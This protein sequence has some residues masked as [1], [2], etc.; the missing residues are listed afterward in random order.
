MCS[1][2]LDTWVEAMKAFAGRKYSEVFCPLELEGSKTS[3]LLPDIA[4]ELTAAF[5]ELTNYRRS[6]VIIGS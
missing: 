2:H 4:K 5:R 3:F 6:C 1:N